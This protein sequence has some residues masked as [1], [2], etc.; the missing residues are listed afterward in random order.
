MHDLHMV[1]T[2]GELQSAMLT[3]AVN[4]KPLL[5]GWRP[6]CASSC[7]TPG[8]GP[9]MQWFVFQNCAPFLQLAARARRETCTLNFGS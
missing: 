8:C 2:L 5:H 4:A 9:C 1:L 7:T 6:E 3:I